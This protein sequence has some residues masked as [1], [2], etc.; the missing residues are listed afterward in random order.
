MSRSKFQRSK[1]IK[2]Y[3]VTKAKRLLTWHNWP[4]FTQRRLFRSLQDVQP[5]KPDWDRP[6]QQESPV[7]AFANILGMSIVPVTFSTLHCNTL[8]NWTPVQVVH[9]DI[10]TDSQIRTGRVERKNINIV[11]L[12]I[13]I[14]NFLLST[15]YFIYVYDLCLHTKKMLSVQFHVQLKRQGMVKYFFSDIN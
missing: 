1:G 2:K 13:T 8:H 15:Y 5:D 14:I 12:I 7:V 10:Q 6:V 4:E 11:A 9:W 3:T